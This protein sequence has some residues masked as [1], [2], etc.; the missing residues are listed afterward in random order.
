MER[1]AIP[2]ARWSN[3]EMGNKAV[4]SEGKESFGRRQSWSCLPAELEG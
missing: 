3:G 1:S 2:I 4:D